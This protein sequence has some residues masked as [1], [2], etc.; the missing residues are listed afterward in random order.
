M[1]LRP[2]SPL[3]R[4]FSI[5]ELMVAMLIGLIGMIIIFQVFEVSEGIKRTTTSGGDAQQN[6]AIALYVLEQDLRNAGMGFNDTPYAGCNVVGYDSTRTP[7]N[8]PAVGTQMPL[9]PVYIVPGASDTASDQISIFYGSQSLIVNATELT[10][11]MVASTDPLHVTNRFGFRAGD[12]ILLHEPGT[13]KNC[14]IIEVTD[15]PNTP[16]DEVRHA[17]GTYN[18]PWKGGGTTATARF[19]PAGGM[20]VVYAVPNLVNASRVF[21]LGNLYDD[22]AN[23]TAMPVYNTYAVTN[24]ALSVVSAFSTSAPAAIADN[25]V[26]LRALYALDDGV[27]N[28]TVTY[29]PALPFT[30]GDGRIDRYVDATT[31]NAMPAPQPWRYIVAVR[32]A[33][34]AR[35]AV[36]EKPS[37]GLGATC[38]TTTAF[39]TWSAT[40]WAAAPQNFKVKFDLS[41][42]VVAPDDWKC[43]RY[44]LFETT[45]PLRNWIWKSS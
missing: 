32:I 41:A 29:T 24:N 1:R 2:P 21:N 10:E 18:L 30:A 23:G 16:G 7:Q 40:A 11:N 8:F 15:V 34:V 22:A 35:S 39:P 43:Y 14:V 17:T 42:T 9:S 37:G 36:A 33:V 38:D 4:G 13:V 28:G 12:L 6:G 45:I 19:N 31:L 5:I 26:H 25:M 20:G 3:P 44:R 27:D